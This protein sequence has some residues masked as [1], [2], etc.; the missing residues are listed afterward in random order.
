MVTKEV[1]R[2]KNMDLKSGK[3][4]HKWNKDDKERCLHKD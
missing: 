4:K 3:C 1:L 2:E